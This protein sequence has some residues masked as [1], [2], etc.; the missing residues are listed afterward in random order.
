MSKMSELATALDEL[1]EVGHQLV[2]CGEDLIQAAARVKECFSDD[3]EE[4]PKPVK[5]PGRRRTAKSPE[6]EQ[7]PGPSAE[8]EM[9][10]PKTYTK[11]EVR[12]MLAD[13]SQSGHR[14]EAKA[15]VKKYADGGSLT[16]IDP[17]RYPDLVQEVQDC[18]A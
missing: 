5:A 4:E 13:L 9:P 14:D 16:D 8:P 11:E 3:A 6:P 18:Y 7:E 12:A 10:A 2:A 17:A 1:T 15:L